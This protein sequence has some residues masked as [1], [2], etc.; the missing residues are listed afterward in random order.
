[1][2]SP[3]YMYA[4][5]LEENNAKLKRDLD[6]YRD[7]LHYLIGYV[8][9]DNDKLKDKIEKATPGLKLARWN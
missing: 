6:L 2:K 7:G 1:M 3:E 8:G 9:G 4:K 5:E